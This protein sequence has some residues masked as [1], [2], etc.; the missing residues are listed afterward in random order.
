[1]R[2]WNSG[3]C[4]DGPYQEERFLLV[5]HIVVHLFNSKPQV[6]VVPGRISRTRSCHSGTVGKQQKQNVSLRGFSLEVV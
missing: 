3:E 4:D 1:M 2:E 5:F 6:P